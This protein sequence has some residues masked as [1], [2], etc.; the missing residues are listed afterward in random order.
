MSEACLDRVAV[1]CLPKNLIVKRL[2]WDWNDPSA[3]VRQEILALKG[4]G[5]DICLYL[6]P[7]FKVVSSDPARDFFLEAR[8]CQREWCRVLTRQFGSSNWKTKMR[9][10]KDV[11]ER[12]LTFSGIMFIN[13]HEV[14][15]RRQY[16]LEADAGLHP[17]TDVVLALRP[18]ADAR[19]KDRDWLSLAELSRSELE[20]QLTASPLDPVYVLPG[21]T[22]MG[23]QTNG[24]FYAEVLK[25]SREWHRRLCRLLDTPGYRRLERQS[26]WQTKILVLHGA[27]AM[28]GAILLPDHWPNQRRKSTRGVPEWSTDGTVPPEILGLS[29]ETFHHLHN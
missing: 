13:G 25:R 1:P 19:L 11:L 14:D 10:T 15:P 18:Y 28:N 6:N 3:I 22:V 12:R 17:E 24:A 26:D 9:I 8:R 16:L 7:M 2:T 5:H 21:I 23:F 27:L 4:T 20:N 29:P